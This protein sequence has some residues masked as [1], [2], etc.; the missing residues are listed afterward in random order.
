MSGAAGALW[1]AGRLQVLEEHLI[2]GH[3]VRFL[4]VATN[5]LGRPP[6][7]PEV[8]FA[9]LPGEGHS[10]GLLMAAALLWHLGET[11]LNLGT[12]VPM[13]HVVTSVRRSDAGRV[14]PSETGRTARLAKR[15]EETKLNDSM[16]EMRPTDAE[17][18]AAG[19]K[20]PRSHG[21]AMAAMNFT[22]SRESEN[23]RHVDCLVASKL[24]LW[25]DS[26]PPQIKGNLTDK[27]VGH[28]AAQDF[29]GGELLP[30]YRDQDCL[31][32]PARAFNP[33]LRYFFIEPRDGR[34][35]PKGVIGGVRGL[36]PEE[37]TPFRV[38]EVQEE[39]LTVDLNHPLAGRALT[40][41]ARVLDIWAAREGHGGAC[42]RKAPGYWI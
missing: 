28:V 39:G 40:L 15:Q 27:P 38:A 3:L 2:T 6:G 30:H 4:D 12:D 29:A 34:S 5:W 33:K 8:L 9:A 16:L 23:G 11:T 22:L 24:N 7:N 36:Y 31:H 19:E 13:D 42:C 41:E 37:L 20:P 32:I 1:A 21:H 10:L 17:Q 14:G 26:L 18:A 25:R 35:Y